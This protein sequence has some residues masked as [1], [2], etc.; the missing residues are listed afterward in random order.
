MFER[1]V[2]TVSR[3]IRCPIIRKGD[4]LP[5][6]VAQAVTEA[7]YSEGFVI[8]DRD[9]VAVTESVVARA[10]GNYATCD[11][12][13]KDVRMKFGAGPVGVIFPILSRNR[14][15][16]CL[17]GIAR[18]ADK[19]VLM[20]SYPSDEVG[21][22]LVSL[23]QLDEAG[24]DPYTD[25]LDLAKYREL[26][27]ENRHPFTGMDYVSYYEDIITK[28]GAE[29]EIIFANRPQAILNYTKNVLTCDI[30][31]RFRSKRLLKAAGAEIVL[32]MDDILTASVDGSGFNSKYGLLGSNKATEESVKLF[33]EN[34]EEFVSK[35]REI[36]EDLTGK[37]IEVM[38]YGDG[39]FKDPQGKIW[40]LADPVVSPAFTEGLKGTPNELKLKYLADN[41]FKDL[42]GEELKNAI[43]GRIK[44]KGQNLVG[45]MASEGTTPRQLT[46]LIGSLSD[47]TSGSGDKGTPVVL[48]QG[49]FDNY[50]D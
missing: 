34:G 48:I 20:L 37:H 24:I 39:A 32:G 8:R 21:N 15:A 38:I 18:G 45:K 11:A 44:E 41:D 9:V 4:D 50:T 26:F 17:K 5:E 29:A 12:I 2:G 7:A 19:I 23:A 16:M 6:I 28:E 14:F 13:A 10:Q 47:L 31:T 30:H 36:L 3:G 46:D 42:S 22:Q 49:Y 1:R 35:T 25:V 40:E 43:S 27:G 33:P